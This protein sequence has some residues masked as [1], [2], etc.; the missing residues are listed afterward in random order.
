MQ[1][2]STKAGIHVVD[3]PRY[4]EYT[5]P[6][7]PDEEMDKHELGPDVTFHF[8][9][10]L[11]VDWKGIVP[12]SRSHC[13]RS[14]ASLEKMKETRSKALY[15][16]ICAQR[17]ERFVVAC[18]YV[19]GHMNESLRKVLRELCGQRPEMLDYAEELQALSVCIQR[20]VGNV[21]NFH[22]GQPYE[23]RRAVV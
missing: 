22:A 17:G 18:F 13:R 6:R 8:P 23:R 1:R 16:D 10:A 21:L 12:S 19:T 11:T 20:G 2:L 3:E 9:H 7:D 4:P 5:P 15:E 14:C